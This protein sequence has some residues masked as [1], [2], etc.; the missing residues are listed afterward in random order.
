MA[1]AVGTTL[2][3][4]RL[5]NAQA[6]EGRS[7]KVHT[8]K[9]PDPAHPLRTHA[10]PG[11]DG[12]RGIAILLV[13]LFHL[14]AMRPVSR[15]D[16]W[17]YH[18]TRYGWSG[19]DLFFVLSGFLITG[20]LIDAKGTSDNYFRNF[21]ARRALR[22]LPLYYAFVAGL[23]LLYPRVGGA[24]VAAE[25]AVLQHNQ[26]WVWT[27]VVNWLVARVG[28]FTTAT[29]LGTGGFWSLSIEEQFYLIWPVVILLVPRR[30]L[31]RVCFA[32]VI[33]TPVIRCAM[34]AFGASWAAIFAVTFARMDGIAMGA[35]IAVIARS[36]FGL[37]YIKR[38]VPVVAAL[39]LM[40]LVG[41][42]IFSRATYYRAKLVLILQCT[43][44]VW[45]WGALLVGTLTAM[46]GS[47]LQRV[48]YTSVLR[49]FGKYSYALY[50]FHG[51]MNRLFTRFGF[52]AERGFTVGGFVLPWQML[53]LMVSS[54]ASLAV[55]YASWHL[56]EKHFLRLKVFFP[57][58]KRMLAPKGPPLETTPA[59][60]LSGPVAALSELSGKT[61]PGADVMSCGENKEPPRVAWRARILRWAPV[62]LPLIVLIGTGLRGLDFGL[63]WD[64]RPWQIGPV[65]HMVERVTPLP[66]Y[67]DY[68][69]FDYWLNLLVLLPDAFGSRVAGENLREHLL[70]V[71]DS[72]AFLLRLRSVYL[73]ITSLS[74][75]WV[76]LLCLQ[77]GGAWLGALFAAS[78]LACSWEV[79]YHLRWVATDGMLMQ[80][81]VLAVLLAIRALDNRREFWL[82]SAAV[83][84]GLGFATKYPGGLLILPVTLA[85]FFTGQ[86]TRQKIIRVTKVAALFV[87]VFLAITPATVLRPSNLVEGVLYE[88]KHYATGHGGH[89]VGRGFDHARHMFTYF[90]TVLWSP[91]FVIALLVFALSVVGLITIVARRSVAGAVF[92]IF[93]VSYLLY[94]STQGTMVLR[95]LL[96]V[97]PFFAI[98]AADG[99]QLIARGVRAR[100]E[101]SSHPWWWFLF[102]RA[103]ATLL[104]IALC[105]NASWLIASAEAIVAKRTDRF[106]RDTA[107]YI[108]AHPAVKFLLSP[109]VKG[110]LKVIA[111]R[112]E[113]VTLKPGEADAFVLYAREGM[114]RWHDWPAN[115]WALTQACFGPREVNFNMYPGWW[116]DDRILVI[117]HHRADQIS[118]HIAGVSKDTPP[119]ESALPQARAA[120][121]A[122]STPIPGKSLPGSWA[123]NGIATYVL[124]PIDPRLLISHDEA[125]SI[126]GDVV[127][128]PT[129][130]GWELDGRGCSF[131][132]P[133]DLVVRLTII[134]TNAFGLERNDP[135][136]A[137]V[138][139]VGLSA[140]VT[141]GGPLGDVRLLA[142]SVNSAVAVY[143]SGGSGGHRTRLDMA[144]EFAVKALDNLDA[145][146][147]SRHSD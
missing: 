25:A 18:F 130:G 142:R 32:L 85:A 107:Q 28:D 59:A 5:E 95:N 134:S 81:A 94:F 36:S 114:Q 34:A 139:N 100:T 133:D 98:A 90:A 12:V 24:K 73:V 105:F 33:M 50:L 41:V 27:H 37:N 103:W 20:I 96:A 135:Q 54:F 67:Y 87:A 115:R 14:V 39:A 63:H 6:N 112:L 57:T 128:G 78:L 56:Y 131:F 55:A 109:R 117:S 99:A 145:I 89:T 86:T 122:L 127:T 75:V 46:P 82:F 62:L 60:L 19:V 101:P 140:Y 30:Q 71:L 48:T 42:E 116:G 26:W 64:E 93:P 15:I 31:L 49:T 70:H 4:Q 108:Q 45:L 136:S 76:Y 16:E 129:T 137:G 3:R 118:L 40:G 84:G 141:A 126:V 47:L 9:E 35:T 102:P 53:Y 83:V 91:Y 121:A 119:A 58:R 146:A 110:D 7:E 104:V 29:P 8:L 38:F 72:H 106:I 66:G 2:P 11:L 97:V 79:A 21:Y 113:N 23:L 74:L 61:N 88:M 22:I 68:P 111:P 44:F 144:K 65:K 138:S 143:L 17:F 51:H 52:D 120:K 43:L 10:L 1:E 77:R 69:S 123:S 92:L 124:P 13:M 147:A 132:G 125:E 80:F